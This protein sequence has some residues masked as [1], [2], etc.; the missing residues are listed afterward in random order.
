MNDAGYIPSRLVTLSEGDA[1]KLARPLADASFTE[2]QFRVWLEGQAFGER[3]QKQ[4]WDAFRDERATVRLLQDQHR[5]K[6]AQALRE[7][8]GAYQPRRTR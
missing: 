2:A 7:K 1:H 5:I 3:S 8:I 6:A 4:M